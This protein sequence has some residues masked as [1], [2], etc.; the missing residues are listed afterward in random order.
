M[1]IRDSGLVPV[2]C[3]VRPARVL[4]SKT[5]ACA[6]ADLRLLKHPGHSVCI[7]PAIFPGIRH[8]RSEKG[9]YTCIITA[10]WLLYHEAQAEWYNIAIFSGS[11]QSRGG[12][13]RFHK[14]N[15]RIVAIIPYSFKL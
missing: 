13:W 2:F 9:Q 1:C 12:K 5:T 8:S 4:Q 3:G 15:S 6:G 7:V 10:L 11:R 14:Y